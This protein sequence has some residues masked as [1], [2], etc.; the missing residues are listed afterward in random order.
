MAFGPRHLTADITRY[1]H[2]HG[3]VCQWRRWP[4]VSFT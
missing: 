3:V 2:K 4:E 1:I